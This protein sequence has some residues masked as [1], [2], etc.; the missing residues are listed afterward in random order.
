MNWN[1]II[2]SVVSIVVTGLI[3]V[4]TTYLT[5]LINSKIS[6]K[7]DAATLSKLTEIISNAVKSVFQTYVQ[8]LKDSGTFNEEAQKTALNKA[9]ELINGELTTELKTYITDNY[10]DIT[11]WLTNQIEATI[12]ALKK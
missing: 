4:L 2:L 5:K 11:T 3:G 6:D 8:S 10:G 12:Y 9:L 7:K 1:E